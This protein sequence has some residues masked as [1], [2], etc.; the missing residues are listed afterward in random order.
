MIVIKT[1]ET[2]LEVM[3]GHKFIW[4]IICQTIGSYVIL[5]N[6]IYKYSSS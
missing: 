1:E 4:K 2:L 5:K 6:D 3:A